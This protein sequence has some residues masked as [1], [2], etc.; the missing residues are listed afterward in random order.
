MGGGCLCYSEGDTA[1]VITHTFEK[2]PPLKVEY[3]ARWVFLPYCIHRLADGRY[4]VLNRRYKPLGSFTAQWVKYEDD[5]SACALNITPE[6]AKRLSWKGS[7]DTEVIHLYSD[8]CLPEESAD[9]LRA[10]SERLQVLMKLRAS[11][12]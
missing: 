3:P 6:A 8:A 1:S 11:T 4:I 9:H 12:G 5:P 10:Y 2:E 7:D